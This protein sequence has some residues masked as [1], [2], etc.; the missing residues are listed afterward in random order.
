MITEAIFNV[1][2]GAA[3]KAFGLLPDI[4]WTVDTSA[5]DYIY[6][7]MSMVAYLMPFQTVRNIMS[8]IIAIIVF[9]IVVALIRA[10]YG[11]IPFV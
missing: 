9:R 7:I 1:L 5:W 4:V 3:D 10:V 2:F 11:F 8:M 6:D